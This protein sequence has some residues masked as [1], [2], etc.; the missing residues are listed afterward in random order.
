MGLVKQFR[1]FIILL[2]GIALSL[3][4]QTQSARARD[5]SF[6]LGLGVGTT[7]F[8]LRANKRLNNHFGVVLGSNKI[9]YTYNMKDKKLNTYNTNVTFSAAHA[10]LQFYPFSRSGLH[11]EAGFFSDAP[12]FKVIAVPNGNGQFKV[13]SNFYNSKDVGSLTG[14]VVFEKEIA[15]YFLLGWGRRVGFKGMYL[16]ASLGAIS[17]GTPKTRLVNKNCRL[18]QNLRARGSHKIGYHHQATRISTQLCDAFKVVLKAEE[19]KVNKKIEKFKLWPFASIGLA[20][21]F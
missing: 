15:P 13:G 14:S 17:Y 8:E 1:N 10:G 16:N 7:G 19:T 2:I 18:D 5:S 4:A 12:E 3:P 21:A 9:D 20:Y 11:L 6:S